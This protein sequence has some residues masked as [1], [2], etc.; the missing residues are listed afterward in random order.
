L[1]LIIWLLTADSCT[2]KE[3]RMF[4]FKEMV[5]ILKKRLKDD[6][7][8]V[9]KIARRE[10]RDPFLILV[11]T[12]LSLRT[13]DELT[14][15][16]ME[17]LAGRARTPEELLR[18]PLG[19]LQNLIYPVGFYRN[20][21]KVLINTA[22]TIMETYNGIVPDSIDELLAIK[23]VGRKT[24]NLV[25]SEA[26]GKPGICVDTHVHRIS[27]R[28]GAV[29]TKNPH[30]TEEALRKILPKQYWIIYNTLLVTFGK[31][32]CSPLSPRCS[33]CPI[34]HLCARK[35]VTRHR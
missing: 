25:V 11:G 26:Y 20:K 27:N 35:G 33:Q 30:Q 16:V 5:D 6:L 4:P 28:I 34:V 12:L 13:K 23:G 15:E 24:A 1:V 7:P 3:V 31:R 8:S 14:E 21:S 32:I 18:I 22:R 10:R 19:E 17:R 2:L 29:S 9:T